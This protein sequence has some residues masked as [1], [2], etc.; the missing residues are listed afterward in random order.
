MFW[1]SRQKQK[2]GL[3]GCLDRELF[4]AELEFPKMLVPTL[5]QYSSS[6]NIECAGKSKQQFLCGQVLG[7]LIY[8]YF[9]TLILSCF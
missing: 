4:A 9:I 8:L 2:D 7:A 1:H 3:E 6:V 5:P